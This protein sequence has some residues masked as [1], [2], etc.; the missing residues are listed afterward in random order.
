MSE[1]NVSEVV[2]GE[3]ATVETKREPKCGAQKFLAIAQEFNG[4]ITIDEMAEKTGLS[5]GSVRG[6]QVNINAVMKATGNPFRIKFIDKRKTENG[7]GQH[8]VGSGNAD[9]LSKLQRAAL[10]L[11][12]N[13]ATDAASLPVVNDDSEAEESADVPEVAAV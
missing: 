6:N 3:V 4:K 5:V 13:M 12:G 9:G 10:A 2:S 1:A 11:F 7:G 8:R